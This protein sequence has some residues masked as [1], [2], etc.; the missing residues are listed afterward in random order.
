M[1][2]QERPAGQASDIEVVV[3]PRCTEI[4]VDGVIGAT[5]RDGIVRMNLVNIRSTPDGREQEHA[6]VGRLILSRS[7]VRNLHKALGQVLNGLQ[8]RDDRGQAPKP[9]E[10][11]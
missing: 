5:V 8:R 10:T 11:E 4:F 6:V 9:A 7:A 2:D 3:D 1:S